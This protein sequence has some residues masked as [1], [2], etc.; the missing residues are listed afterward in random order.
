MKKFLFFTVLIFAAMQ[1]TGA[2]VD[3]AT[4]KATAQQYAVSKMTKGQLVAPSSVDVKLVKQEM[5][6]EQ[7][8]TAVYY[9]FNTND[10]F[11][12]ISG[13]DRAR[14]VLAYGDHPIGDINRMPANMKYWLGIYKQELEYLQAH[15]ELQADQSINAGNPRGVSV[16]PLL[17]A[18]WDQLEPY[19]NHCPVYNGQLC[20]TGC[21]A[22]SLAMVFYY[23][24]FP[25]GPV[26]AV[27]GYNNYSYGFQVEAL[28]GTTFDWENMIDDYTQ[29]YTEAQA[30]A[31]AWLMRYIGQEE[32]MDYSPDGS[33]AYSSDILRAVKF[34]GYNQETAALHYK[35]SYNNNTWAAM[36]QEEL[37]NNRPIVY[38]GYDSYAG[39]HAFNVDG[40]D[41]TDDTY[42][43][44]WGWSGDYNC[45]CALNAF[46]DG[47]YYTFTNDQ[48]MVI[49]IQP[50][51]LGPTITTSAMNMAIESY[52]EKTAT[53]VLSVF[54]YYLDHDV[55]VT[56]NDPNGVYSIDVN[57][58]ALSE[59]ENG[60]DITIT[61]APQEVGTHNATITLSSQGAE[62]VT[63]YL[64]GTGVLETHDPVMT[65]AENADNSSI[66]L[67][68]EDNT[69]EIN[70]TSYRIEVGLVPFHESRIK[71]DFNMEYDGNS[72]TDW[73]S[74]LDEITDVAGWTGYKVY[75]SNGYLILG[76]ATKRGWIETPALDMRG[77][78]NLLTVKVSAM[79]TSSEIAVPL[80][81]SCGASDTTIIV[82]NENTEQC[83]L[84]PCPASTAATVRLENSL[85]GKRVLVSSL[86]VLAGDD[87]TPI[88]LSR[89]SYVE[90]ITDLS[91]Q[92]ADMNP[93]F[94]GLRVQAV[95]TDGSVSQWSNRM[96]VNLDWRHG[97]VNRD[98]EVN[99]ADVNT[100][101]DV[102]TRDTNEVAVS[103]SD[104]NG[105]GEVNIADVNALIDLILGM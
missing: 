50:P 76:S 3:L 42:H 22:T 92:L 25:V 86:E 100:I 55:T 66:N 9:I 60:K 27:S 82:Y 61:Y 16:E 11:I 87:Y 4:A 36:I 84:M 79:S 31:V 99:I 67:Q 8:G 105:D 35:Y 91:Y 78:N 75:R 39:G 44:N 101:I 83:V 104:V 46:S 96:F 13:D 38:S 48:Q 56:L 88:D 43:I 69:P 73:S 70:V 89:M 23:W 63:I 47:E 97:D 93:G 62:D 45:Y 19:Y 49:G 98:Y 15:P 6:S 1:V 24:K 85:S 65:V 80:K 28:P 12:I 64:D 103:A 51:Y 14:T 90:G 74:S 33:G 94:Y 57:H 54:G 32:H 10:H 72:N 34:F 20:V 5:N 71:Q 95:Y 26:P 18:M 77:N 7:P 68:W 29:G 37:I 30:D 102:I 17:T 59:V 41:A 81:L 53:Q 21:P 58:I 52:A 40:Y 2:N